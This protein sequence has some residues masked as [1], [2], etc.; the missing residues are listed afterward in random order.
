MKD[1]CIIYSGGVDST[2]ML[3]KY[4]ND[5][6]LALSFYYGG[7]HNKQELKYARMNCQKLMIKHKV[8]D[9]SF[10]FKNM[11]TALINK[12]KNIPKG[13]YQDI[14]MRDTVIP[15]RNGVMLSIAAAISDNIGLKKIL[16]GTHSGD[17]AIYPDCRTAFNK[18]MFSAI[19]KGT[20]NC[21]KLIVPFVSYQ[22]YEIINE[23]N[24][25]KLP[26]DLSLI[27]YSCYEGKLLHCGEC[28]TCVARKEAFSM[29]KINDNTKYKT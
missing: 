3:Y 13:H 12:N 19:E 8:I 28:G 11:K 20:S 17:H 21:V 15:F 23:W 18:A 5:I 29:A 1:S 16:I 4:K 22:K 2:V 24:K 9:I 10:L 14:I 25:L 26:Y 7:K 27:S 6:A